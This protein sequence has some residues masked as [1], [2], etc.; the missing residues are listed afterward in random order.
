MSR[1]RRVV[2]LLPAATEIVAALGQVETLVAVSHEC[3][4]PPEVAALPR[5][6]RCAIHGNALPSD[7]IYRCPSDPSERKPYVDPAS[8]QI[9]GVENRASFLM[10]SLLSHK[11]RRYGLWNLMRFVNEVGTS[12]FICFSERNAAVF[13]AANGGNPRQD[14]YDIWLG[15]GRIRPWLA[16]G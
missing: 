7:A 12:Q 8:G 14:D 4:H 13:V 1:A 6:T 2:S 5:A 9:D 3:D 16:W 10:N 15:T 11:T